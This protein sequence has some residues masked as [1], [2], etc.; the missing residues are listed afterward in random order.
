[1]FRYIS[2][3]IWSRRVKKDC[4]SIFKIKIWLIKCN[5]QLLIILEKW[6]I[7]EKEKNNNQPLWMNDFYFAE[8]GDKYPYPDGG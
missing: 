5:Y 7:L 2:T 4:V 1:M 3:L 6:L 8:L